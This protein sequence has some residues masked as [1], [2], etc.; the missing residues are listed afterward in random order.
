MELGESKMERGRENQMGERIRKESNVGGGEI[1]GW[2]VRG[3]MERA[4]GIREES[5]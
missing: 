5:C 3:E 1:I 4:N 2:R